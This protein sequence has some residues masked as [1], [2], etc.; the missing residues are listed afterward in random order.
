MYE[1]DILPINV[2]SL[3]DAS[4]LTDIY[5]KTKEVEPNIIN[6]DMPSNIE[7]DIVMSTP[8][9]IPALELQDKELENISTGNEADYDIAP[10][11]QQV[12]IKDGST[13]LVFGDHY[14]IKNI[15]LNEELG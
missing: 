9:N 1:G 4:Y 10:T 12:T 14:N 2:A 8:N 6:E 3:N 11:E 5:E 15:D 13:N 7:D